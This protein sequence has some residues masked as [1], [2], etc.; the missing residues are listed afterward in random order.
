MRNNDLQL[1]KFFLKKDLSKIVLDIAELKNEKLD[2]KIYFSPSKCPIVNVADSDIGSCFEDYIIPTGSFN[3]EFNS[4][5]VVSS[6]LDK[7]LSFSEYS[8]FIYKRIQDNIKQIFLEHDTVLLSY[9]GG[10]DSLVVLSYIIDLG[11]KDR[12]KFV[13]NNNQVSKSSGCLYYNPMHKLLIDHIIQL[14]DLDVLWI[15]ITED[16]IL[17][18]INNKALE[19]L[20]TYSTSCLFDS[21]KNSV[22][23][24]GWHGNQVL[25]HKYIFWDEIQLVRPQAKQEIR[26]FLSKNKNFYSSS[27][28]NYDTQNT[29]IIPI[30]RVHMLQKSWNWFN[31]IN[32]NRIYSPLGDD[33]IF[34]MLRQIDFS[35]VPIDII[36]NASLA[37]D[38]IHKNVDTMLDE[39]I[40]YESLNDGDSLADIDELPIN[41]I[42]QEILQIPRELN[43]S[44]EGVSWLKYELEAAKLSGRIPLNTIVSLKT[45]HW[46]A[47]L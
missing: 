3:Y 43:H 41:K 31:G 7:S 19:H 4:G 24:G 13:I 6:L 35:Q 12:I 21:F 2:T 8:D 17:E 25:L 44:V 22:F 18:C 9:S 30:E 46:L 32:G 34:L 33:E 14:F 27:L 1:D 45:L 40:A 26:D 37:R 39:F 10:I 47:K 5:K 20:R 11:F 29:N 16:Y 42:N 28:K 15:D 38:F 23:V 36:A